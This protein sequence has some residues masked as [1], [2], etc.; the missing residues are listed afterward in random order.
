MRE[1][2]RTLLESSGD[3]AG[4]AEDV[5]RVI[6][7]VHTQRRELPFNVAVT[8]AGAMQELHEGILQLR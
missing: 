2:L 6:V 3:V 1:L 5:E 8:R 7:D 4:D